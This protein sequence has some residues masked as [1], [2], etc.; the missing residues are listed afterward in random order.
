MFN[1]DFFK[2]FQL[3]DSGL[4]KSTNQ[5]PSLEDMKL[6][7]ISILK[8]QLI[9][10]ISDAFININEELLIKGKSY[11]VGTTREWSGKRYKKI[12]PG[13][14]MRVY[15]GEQSRGENQAILNTIKKIKSATSISEL[16]AIV[17]DNRKRF[18]TSDNKSNAIVQEFLQIA[19]KERSRIV[20]KKSKEKE[21]HQMMIR[22]LEKELGVKLKPIAYKFRKKR[23][24]DLYTSKYIIEGDALT[25][26]NNRVISF[27]FADKNEKNL[28]KVEFFIWVQGLRGKD[29]SIAQFTPVKTLYD[30]S[31][32]SNKFVYDQVNG[33]MKNKIMPGQSSAEILKQKEDTYKAFIKKGGES[34]NTRYT[35][36]NKKEFKIK[37]LSKDARYHTHT[38]RK[39]MGLDYDPK[40]TNDKL[41]KPKDEYLDS[42]KY[43]NTF[44]DFKTLEVNKKQTREKKEDNPW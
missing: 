1:D 6:K 17:N 18:M 14:W 41:F 39:L 25:G 9:K 31:G 44:G 16:A 34:S 24:E 27:M 20:E 4:L 22:K 43:M 37:L 28:Q 42:V 38:M 10:S 2:S 33:F 26:S 21:S 3:S 7:L 15:S 40:Y 5:K 36:G 13:K 8:K 11:P 32:K 30:L 12:S 35:L 29:V 23:G 19:K